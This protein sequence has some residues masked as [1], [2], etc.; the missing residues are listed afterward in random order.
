DARG[1]AV[2][3]SGPIDSVGVDAAGNL[4][5]ALNSAHQIAV[6]AHD[7]I[8]SLIGDGSD[9]GAHLVT[10]GTE[11]VAV[12]ATARVVLMLHPDGSSRTVDLGVDPGTQ[13][14]MPALESGSTLWLTDVTH[15]ALIG[16]AQGADVAQTV[17]LGSVPGA[18][19][20][21][22]PSGAVVYLYDA[23]SGSLSGVDT[24]TGK[25]R[26]QKLSV[27]STD[28]EF[29]G[30]D[31]LVYVN[32]FAGPKAF[33]GNDLGVVTP[34]VKYSAAKPPPKPGAPAKKPAVKK[35]TPHLH[36]KAGRVR[37]R[38]RPRPKPRARP[39]PRPKPRPK[40]STTT[41]TNP[42]STTT[43]TTPGSTTTTTPGSTTTTTTPGSTTTTTTPGSTTTTVPDSTTT[44]TAPPST[45]TTTTAPPGP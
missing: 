16:L 26:T 19:G 32:D 18:L 8:E 42:G 45:T 20:P 7:R 39:K 27:G 13:L 37:A 40:A 10:V 6:V 44:T 28:A 5:A 25:A 21:P 30:K 4:Y 11:V 17:P 35:L 41:T 22:Q 43:T 1:D 15:R 24:G 3:L 34:L 38:P 2:D 14:A 29:F 33:V 31:G 36:K 12:D 9:A 23:P